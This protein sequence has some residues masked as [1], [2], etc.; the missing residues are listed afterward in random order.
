MNYS[1]RL[2][3]TILVMLLAGCG[4]PD[5][6]S[7]ESD[8]AEPSLANEY[9]LDDSLLFPEGGAF[10]PV[11]RAFF[12]GSLGRGNVTRVAAAGTQTVFFA[13]TGEPKRLTLG[14]AV[15]PQRRRLWVCSILNEGH[16]P[17]SIWVFD[18]ASGEW[19]YDIPLSLLTAKASCN[20]VTVDDSG[21][22]YVTDRENPN[23]YRIDL[24]AHKMR[25]WASHTMLKPA[26]IGMNGIAVT[27]D[28]SAVLV[29][30]YS[31]ARL[32][33]ISLADPTQVTEVKLQ[34]D[35]FSGGWDLLS[36]ADG[37]AFHGDV[38]YVAFDSRVMQVTPTDSS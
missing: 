18:L 22:A 11:D 26:F 10:D 19:L 34:G 36:G 35:S 3:L 24:A 28:G 9:A 6:G 20:D 12:V 27:P 4:E 1:T 33:R 14:M 31:P 7:E 15:D 37:I 25:I 38:L 5:A 8:L 23:V 21:L 17:G 32:A 29:T 2:L 16:K 30:K 13:G